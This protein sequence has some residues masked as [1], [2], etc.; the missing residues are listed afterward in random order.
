MNDL[1][2]NSDNI[3]HPKQLEPLLLDFLKYGEPQ[4]WYSNM[5]K[6][7]GWHCTITMRVMCAGSEFKVKSDYLDTPIKAVVQ[8]HNRML[9]S[10]KDLKI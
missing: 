8:C 2:V 6:G 5:R 7:G 10:L 1:A 4:L 9:K 3:I